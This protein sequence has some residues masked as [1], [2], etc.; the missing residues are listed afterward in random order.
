M[1][2]VLFITCPMTNKPTPTDFAVS[3]GAFQP[4]TYTNNLSQCRHC[5]QMH[6]WNGEDAYFQGETQKPPPK[7]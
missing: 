4:G 6:T 3:R 7:Q 1:A 5:G 2:D